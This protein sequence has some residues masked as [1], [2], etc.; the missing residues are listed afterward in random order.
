MYWLDLLDLLRLLGLL[1]LLGLLALLRLVNSARM[2]CR[3]KACIIP[4][5]FILISLKVDFY[6]LYYTAKV[7][8]NQLRRRTKIRVFA[9]DEWSGPPPSRRG[10][11]PH[12]PEALRAGTVGRIVQTNRSGFGP[13]GRMWASAPTRQVRAKTPGCVFCSRGKIYPCFFRFSELLARTAEVIWMKSLTYF[14]TF[15]PLR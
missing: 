9:S 6:Q 4:A 14:F 5:W 1:D 10:R 15:S 13:S 8:K 7:Q 2:D 11:C 12:R 3:I